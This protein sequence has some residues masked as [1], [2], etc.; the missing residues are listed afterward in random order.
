MRFF[1]NEFFRDYNNNNNNNDDDN[2]NNN[3]IMDDNNYDYTIIIN[4]IGYEEDKVHTTK[5]NQVEQIK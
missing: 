3:N 1:V 4:T 5:K 2:N